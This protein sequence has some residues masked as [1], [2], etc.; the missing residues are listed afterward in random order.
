MSSWFLM[1]IIHSSDKIIVLGVLIGSTL[2]YFKV[3]TN[4]KL[5]VSKKEFERNAVD[6]FTI[7]LLN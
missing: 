6:N 1:G 4:D 2:D 3:E 5:S 7:M